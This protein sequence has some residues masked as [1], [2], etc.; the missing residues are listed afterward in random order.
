MVC[1]AL[2]T[3]ISFKDMSSAYILLSKLCYSCLWFCFE[4]Q[5]SLAFFVQIDIQINFIYNYASKLANIDIFQPWKK[6]NTL[7][8]KGNPCEFEKT[9]KFELYT[10]K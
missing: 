3:K 5:T 9:Q 2:G 10:K 6:E 7:F 4:L 8:I 1:V